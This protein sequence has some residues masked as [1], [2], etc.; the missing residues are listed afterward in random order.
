MGKFQKCLAIL[1]G[2]ALYLNFGWGLGTYVYNNAAYSEP[3]TLVAEFWAGPNRCMV[4]ELDKSK[5][6]KN[7]VLEFQI[8]FSLMWPVMLLFISVVWLSH[9]AW[10]LFWLIFWGG[11]AKLLGLG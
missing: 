6:K 1:F 8:I 2:L 4:V 3:Q 11:I 5:L 9:F 10:Y 7:R